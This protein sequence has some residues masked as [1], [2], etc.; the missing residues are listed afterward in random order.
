MWKHSVLAAAVA[1][2]GLGAGLSAQQPGPAGA[3]EKIDFARSDALP[4]DAVKALID[5]GVDVNAKSPKGETALS[6]ATEHGHTAI[7]DL[8]IK[9][10]A[11]EISAPAAPTKKPAPAPS[12]RVAVERS[13]PLLQHADVTFL[14]KSGCVSCHSNSL[15]AMTVAVARRKGLPVDDAA[16]RQQSKL[17]GAY[18][19]SWLVRTRALPIQPHFESGFPY[20][21]DQFISA[22][23]SNWATM[24]LAL[25]YVKPT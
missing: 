16:A 11:T 4:V 10:G 14:Q 22:A 5:R 7:V 1:L 19:E 6:L 21:R 23:G 9:V 20:G 18:L 3:A 25:A 2:A 12:I 8:L 17:I 13:L 24:A 15:A